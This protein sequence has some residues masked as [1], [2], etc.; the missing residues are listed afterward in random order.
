MVDS[1]LSMNALLATRYLLA[2]DGQTVNANG[3]RGNRSAKFKVIA[4]LGNI[5]EQLLQISRHRDLFHG[6]RQ[7][8]ARNPQSGRAARVVSGHQVG[9]MAEKFGH[10]ESFGYAPNDFP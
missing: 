2:T 9:A 1:G 7:F 8:S 6:K 3:G 10:V 4:D 5:E